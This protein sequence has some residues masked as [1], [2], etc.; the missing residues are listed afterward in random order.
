MKNHTYERFQ[1]IWWGSI[2]GQTK[3]EPKNIDDWL[4]WQGKRQEIAEL[5]LQAER[6]ETSSTKLTLAI[7]QIIQVERK[8]N[9]I[10]QLGNLAD[11][12]KCSTAQKAL[13]VTSINRETAN[14]LLNYNSNLLSIL[15]LIIL[16]DN[17]PKL[18]EQIVTQ[19]D[20]PSANFLEDILI[21]S[22]L[23]TFVLNTEHC[24]QQFD[25]ALATKTILDKI[26]NKEALLSNKLK[27]VVQAANN[28]VGLPQ[29]VRKVSAT[30]NNRQTAIALAWYLFITTPDN[31]RL[32]I[33]RT[34]NLQPNIAWL[35]AALTGT[36]SGAYNGLTGIPWSWRSTISQNPS[37]EQENQIIEHLFKNWLGIYSIGSK[38]NFYDHQLYAVANSRKIQPRKTLKI[39]SQ[40][41]LF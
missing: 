13:K 14:K 40:K 12:R 22:Y 34:L 8:I 21:W 28:G 26:S 4:N 10:N 2:I 15:P 35:T 5:I 20:L 16:L 23:I 19:Y 9:N 3:V 31:F 30:G 39:I 32:S 29:L 24:P 7:Q 38:E 6:I 27:L 37:S 36:L 33:Q 17:N 11:S 1:G 25:F 41:C 18:L